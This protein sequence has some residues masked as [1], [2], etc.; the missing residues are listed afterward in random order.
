ML[1]LELERRE[2]RWTQSDIGQLAKIHQP[3]ISLIEQGRLKPTPAQLDR[4]A[5]AFS[6]P[7]D[8]VLRPVVVRDSPPE[9]LVEQQA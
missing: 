4:L 7:P 2:R 9:E 6:I 3:D 8:A 5:R 1:R